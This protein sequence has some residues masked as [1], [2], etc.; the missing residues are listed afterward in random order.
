MNS[1]RPH[2][3]KM[4]STTPPSYSFFLSHSYVTCER[5][6]TEDPHVLH[7]HCQISLSNDADENYEKTFSMRLTEYVVEGKLIKIHAM[8]F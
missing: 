7:D 3:Q 6:S 1:S 2:I 5:L 8:R 4:Q